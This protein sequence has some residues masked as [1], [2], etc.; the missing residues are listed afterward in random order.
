ML[1]LFTDASDTAVGA[2]LQQRVGVAWQPLAFYS[3]KIN[4]AQQKYSPYDRELLT[5]YE[6]IK[7][8]RHMVVIF[9]DHKPLIYA[10]Q[11]R[12]DKCSPRQFR[13]L[14][15]IGQF[16]TDFRHSQGKTML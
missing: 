6:V 3:H 11:Q 7:Y 12:R 5:V 1:A 10:F 14:E 16:F 2:A 8:F 13:H 4:P 9:T 15:F